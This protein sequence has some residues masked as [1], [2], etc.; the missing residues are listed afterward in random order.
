M[1]TAKM[2]NS[3]DVQMLVDELVKKVNELQTQNI[4]MSALNRQLQEQVRM[5]SQ[6]LGD[7]STPADGSEE[8]S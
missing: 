7:L 5:L 3:L 8:D 1:D 2:T 4:M 6:S